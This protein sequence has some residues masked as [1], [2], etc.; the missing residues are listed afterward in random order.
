MPD[1]ATQGGSEADAL[2]R[3]SESVNKD[4][5]DGS[6]HFLDSPFPDGSRTCQG[7]PACQPC[8]RCGG[9]R[10]VPTGGGALVAC[11]DCKGT[12]QS[13]EDR[14][15]E[16]RKGGDQVSTPAPQISQEPIVPRDRSDE[17][18]TF[19]LWECPVHGPLL[20]IDGITEEHDDSLI[21]TP[22][23]PCNH[24]CPPVEFVRYSDH[25]AE[26]ERLTQTLG[27]ADRLAETYRK[28]LVAAE[29][30]VE[31]LREALAKAAYQAGHERQAGHLER[32]CEICAALS[33]A[34]R[35]ETA[36]G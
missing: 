12:G 4:R 11:P 19:T 23:L 35:E 21:H 29:A 18:E 31:R 22:T 24:V 36:D 30:E 32:G 7:C 27:V 10:S 14:S 3:E 13:C 33:P 16:E 8:P 28:N 2:S 20:P 1:P 34:S 5:C 9:S 6:G 25:A 15:D 26:V 17:V